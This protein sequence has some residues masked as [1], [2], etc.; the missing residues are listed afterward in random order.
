M[1]IFK[2]LYYFQDWWSFRIRFHQDW[3]L[4][5]T[6]Y[7]CPL[8]QFSSQLTAAKNSHPPPFQSFRPCVKFPLYHTIT[9]KESF[10]S[11]V[12]VNNC[13]A[14]WQL[15]LVHRALFI[16]DTFY[17][18][19]SY[20]KSAI[21]L[22][23]AEDENHLFS[24]E[25]RY[26]LFT[27]SNPFGTA[28]INFEVPKLICSGLSLSPCYVI[29]DKISTSFILSCLHNQENFTYWQIFRRIESAIESWYILISW[30]SEI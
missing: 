1:L 19:S 26:I 30:I 29:P 10:H 23:F 28:L 16:F 8:T 13:H 15:H 4:G 24:N 9:A 12:N 17:Q 11:S 7:I 3:F 14:L 21:A 25:E 2:P 5:Y 27:H 20:L 22:S 6:W 18:R